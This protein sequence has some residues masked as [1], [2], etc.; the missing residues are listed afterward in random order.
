MNLIKFIRRNAII[1]GL[2]CLSPVMFAQEVSDVSIKKNVQQISE[3]LK[4]LASLEPRTFEYDQEK[5][6]HLKFP[7][8]KQYGFIAEN[9]QSV[10][11]NLVKYTTHTYMFGKNTYRTTK[12]KTVDIESLIPVLVASVQEQQL[13]IEKL[14]AEINRLKGTGTS[15]GN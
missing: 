7:K 2:L 8:G 12:V 4:S 5:Y 6:Q 1:A 15:T 3:P 13:E 10:F 9:M 11:P 14:K